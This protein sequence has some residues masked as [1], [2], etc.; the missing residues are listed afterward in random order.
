M[1]KL[2]LLALALGVV[3][4]ALAAEGGD[5][6]ERAQA[7]ALALA[8]KHVDWRNKSMVDN[9]FYEYV[10]II[11][12]LI[13]ESGQPDTKAQTDLFV[14]VLD[15]IVLNATLS[16]AVFR[17]ALFNRLKNKYLGFIVGSNAAQINHMQEQLKFLM[18]PPAEGPSAVP[19]AQAA[20]APVAPVAPVARVGLTANEK[21][22]LADARRQLAKGKA[23]TP[24]ARAS[25]EKIVRDLEAKQ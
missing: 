23:L 1:K 25:F 9:L 20:P 17:A 18:T 7:E 15:N 24:G 21:N 14:A 3:G 22:I 19:V 8:V 11:E 4:Y 10:G 16:D 12:S 2:L 6:Y 5:A 13:N